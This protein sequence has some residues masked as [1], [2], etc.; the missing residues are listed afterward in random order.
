MQNLQMFLT[1]LWKR[2]VVQFGALY[3]G[4][5]WLLIQVVVLIEDT[6]K[7][8]DWMDQITLVFLAVGFPLALILAWAQETKAPM[9]AIADPK[10][11]FAR[12]EKNASI[13][14]LPFR[15]L[16]SNAEHSF[17]A[18]G[19]AED[20]SSALSQLPQLFVVAHSSARNFEGK[21]QDIRTVGETLGAAYVVEGSIRRIENQLRISVNLCNT[22]TA[23]QIWSKRYD[24][25]IE[26]FFAVQDDIIADVTGTLTKE[27]LHTEFRRVK[28]EHPNSLKAYEY[29]CRGSEGLDHLDGKN[30]S[31]QV[32]WFRKA[33][34][35]DPNYAHGH[36]FLAMGLFFNVAY[37]Y[38]RDP[39]K[40][41]YE[42]EKHAEIAMKLDPKD[43]V[44]LGLAASLANLKGDLQDAEEFAR[45]AVEK[46]QSWSMGH[47]TL[48]YALSHGPDTSEGIDE[49]I[50]AIEHEPDGAG[51]P[52]WSLNLGE[53]YLLAGEAE[54]AETV[55][56][57]AIDS[58][59]HARWGAWVFLA[60]AKESLGKHE[61][62]DQAFATARSHAPAWTLDA[63]FDLL[64]PSKT[65]P[66]YEN[67]KDLMS[68]LWNRCET[69]SNEATA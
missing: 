35:L 22:W 28:I 46:S 48:G 55:I 63:C 31:E 1:Q 69:A 59:L 29:W 67:L 40:D 25:E 57:D 17:L 4:A 37:L 58:G 44:V 32:N 20:I 5:A 54:K 19:L 21:T 45:K 9:Q 43:P 64:N 24:H 2:R 62:A 47:A 51:R 13:A 7:L 27:V 16:S 14:V 26:D 38:S 6:M 18:Q 36:A 30:A 68:T 3:L 34:E 11:S 50:R 60:L 61:H 42:A 41:L 66:G 52:L 49:L 39:L 65:S 8:P 33:V 10:A 15:S 53:A 56:K 12:Q 23:E